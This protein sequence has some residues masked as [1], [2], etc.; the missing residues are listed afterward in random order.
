MQK[1][2]KTIYTIEVLS[3]EPIP[4]ELSMLQIIEEASDGDYSYE[5]VGHAEVELTPKEA[6]EALIAQNSDPEFFGLHED[7]TPV[8]EDDDE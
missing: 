5:C 6:A 4:D 1:F 3:E 2:Y 8:D 7:G